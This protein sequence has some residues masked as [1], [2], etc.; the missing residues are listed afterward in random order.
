MLNG[1]NGKDGAPGKEGQDFMPSSS[2]SS[3]VELSEACKTLR[4]TK[5]EFVPLENVF[6]C[7]LP[8]EKVVF[9]SR[10]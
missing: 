4:A 10:D 7:V 3:V 9:V 1:E 5:N 2:S 8:N 6:D